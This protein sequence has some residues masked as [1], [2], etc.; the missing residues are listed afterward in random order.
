[1]YEHMHAKKSTH[2]H[3]H[4]RARVRRLCTHQFCMHMHNFLFPFPFFCFSCKHTT[5]VVNAILSGLLDG[6]KTV[7]HTG[8]LVIEISVRDTDSLPMRKTPVEILLQ[9][10]H[11]KE[12]R[13]IPATQDSNGDGSSYL[14]SVPPSARRHPGNYSLSVQIKNGFGVAAGVSKVVS[15]CKVLDQQMNVICGDGF[16]PDASAGNEC[17]NTGLPSAK[18]QSA[19]VMVGGKP[20]ASTKGSASILLGSAATS[21]QAAIPFELASKNAT[22]R[23]VELATV[24]HV[25]VTAGQ[26][27]ISINKPGSYALELID[28]S[29]SCSLLPALTAACQAGY[30]NRDNA[31]L[32]VE[33]SSP[34]PIVLAILLGLSLVACAAL[35]Y[36]YIK[37]KRFTAENETRGSVEMQPVSREG[38]PFCILHSC[39]HV[40]AVAGKDHIVI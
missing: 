40:F 28:Q 21:L 22:M 31:C 24:H 13:E 1:M 39:T 25:P 33:S 35:L 32:P 6:G 17:M 30:E 23:L 8:D 14:V 37:R 27:A 19:K 26:A 4:T 11:G 15:T 5:A 18:C 2:A 7:S 12:M 36:L 38:I 10:A 34:V 29:T 9:W 3:T 20:L 16:A